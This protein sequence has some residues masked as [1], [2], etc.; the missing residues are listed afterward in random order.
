MVAPI[1]EV[2]YHTNVFDP[3]VAPANIM[4]E[5]MMVGGTSKYMI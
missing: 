3:S 2:L 5:L 4:E 1:L